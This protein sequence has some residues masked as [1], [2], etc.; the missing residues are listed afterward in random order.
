VYRERHDPYVNECV[1]HRERHDPDVNE[2]AVH[3]EPHHPYVNECV[4]YRKRHHPYV[5]D[6]V[7]FGLFVCLMVFNA[8]FKNIS[9]V[10]GERHIHCNKWLLKTALHEH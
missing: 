8:T 9:V 7:V 2:C 10:F 1:V 4:V 3:R 5:N 6:Y